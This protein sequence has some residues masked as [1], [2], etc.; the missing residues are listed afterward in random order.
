MGRE[1]GPVQGE[2][3][4]GVLLPFFTALGVMLGGSLL[5]GLAALFYPESPFHRMQTLAQDVK[6]WAIVV[7]MGGTFPTLRALDS[8]LFNGEVVHLVRQLGAIMA[9][10]LG[11]QTGFWVVMGLT[12]GRGG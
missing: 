1:V 9:G 8:G 5:G 6:L 11:A 10:F 7:A 4:K 2:I 3:V 12:G